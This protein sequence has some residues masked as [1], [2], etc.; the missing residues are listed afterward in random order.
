MLETL[1]Y[2]IRIGSTPTIL[3]FDLHL[4][5]AY[6]AH[7]YYYYSI[8]IHAA[9]IAGKNNHTTILKIQAKIL[10]VHEYILYCSYVSQFL[11]CVSTVD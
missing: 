5:S 3:Y 11:Y 10:H 9:K 1:D 4:Y 6:A 7:Y 8:G 2:T